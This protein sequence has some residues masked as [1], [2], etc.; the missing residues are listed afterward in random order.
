MKGTDETLKNL[1]NELKDVKRKNVE[2]STTLSVC[3]TAKNQIEQKLKKTEEELKEAREKAMKWESLNGRLK[4]ELDLERMRKQ[5]AKQA[6]QH[7]APPQ[8]QSRQ[9][10]R[11]LSQQQQQYE[12]PMPRA[13]EITP[14]FILQQQPARQEQE[15]LPSQRQKPPQRQQQQEQQLPQRRLTN[16]STSSVASSTKNVHWGSPIAEHQSISGNSENFN[17]SSLQIYIPEDVDPTDTIDTPDFVEKQYSQFGCYR[18][19]KECKC[20]SI[21]YVNGDLQYCCLTDVNVNVSFSL[22]FFTLLLVLF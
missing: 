6:Q 8:Q 11:Q 19:M 1:Q 17:F 15:Q 13:Q 5:L 7:F 21:R 2:T 16:T 9:P 3:R 22:A 20:E 12:R 14:P 18:I 4:N 10:L